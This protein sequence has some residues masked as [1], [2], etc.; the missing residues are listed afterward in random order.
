VKRKPH[1][2]LK[3]ASSSP[4]AIY[5]VLLGYLL[6][7]LVMALALWVTLFALA[8]LTASSP[9][10]LWTCWLLAEIPAAYNAFTRL[11]PEEW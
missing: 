3:K 7:H 8:R 9:L 11:S 10:P 5:P 2:R 6:G 1:A 4:N